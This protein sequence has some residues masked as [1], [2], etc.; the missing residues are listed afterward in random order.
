MRAGRKV[1]ETGFAAQLVHIE[2]TGPVAAD[3]PVG[4]LRTGAA[5]AVAAGVN[6][7][8]RG[9]QIATTRLEHVLLPAAVA[10]TGISAALTPSWRRK[11]E[12]WL[13]EASREGNLA[14]APLY[15]TTPCVATGDH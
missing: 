7:R 9:E 2:A 12:H 8:R 10:R 11:A 3:T 13:I 14:F 5:R 4:S 1:R 15:Y 6:W